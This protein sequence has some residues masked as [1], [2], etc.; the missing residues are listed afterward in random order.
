[1]ILVQ[2]FA[3][4]F[5]VSMAS[6]SLERERAY[7]RKHAAD[8]E[9]YPVPKT[10]Y[11][12]IPE[13][14]RAGATIIT[15]IAESVLLWRIRKKRYNRFLTLGFVLPLI[16]VLIVIPV[17]AIRMGLYYNWLAPNLL[18]YWSGIG[19]AHV[20]L[21]IMIW[22]SERKKTFIPTDP[23]NML[24]EFAEADLK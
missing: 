22:Q 1:M 16:F 3:L 4:Y 23:S 18:L 6:W 9:K 19:I 13:A 12:Y 17:I 24:D 2:A 7:E 8:I 10:S 21:M 11:R 20:F 5:N 14:V 15:L